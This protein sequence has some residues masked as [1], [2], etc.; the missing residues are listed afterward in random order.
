MLTLVNTGAVHVIRGGEGKWRSVGEG[1]DGA[2][3]ARWVRK[4][5]RRKYGPESLPDSPGFW[6]SE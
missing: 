1:K 5:E 6:K 4:C 3:A 2:P